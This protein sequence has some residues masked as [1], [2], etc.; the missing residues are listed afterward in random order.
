[1]NVAQVESGR[2]FVLK[3]HR[4]PTQEDKDGM[5]RSVLQ[6]LLPQLKSPNPLRRRG[7]AGTIRNCCLD[8]D[9]TWWL[10]NVVKISTHVLYPLAGPEELDVD[11][12]RGLD[13]DLWLEG[14]DK[15]REVDHLTRL[16]LVES[17]LFL[18]SSGRKAQET[19]RRER[20]SVVLRWAEMVEE[21]EDVSEKMVECIDLLRRDSKD[22]GNDERGDE[23][24]DE[25]PS[26]IGTP[27]AAKQVGLSDNYDD[28]D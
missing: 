10:L 25:P 18:A 23:N 16:Y 4:K 8:P 15:E 27:S 14:P 5:G 28:I 21:Q 13:P 9:F 3:I 19:L 1:M 20:V 22:A 2:L 24:D 11:E 6:A 26:T 12:K 17:V 7:V